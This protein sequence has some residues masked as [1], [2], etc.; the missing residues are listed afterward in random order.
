MIST[1]AVEHELRGCSY[2]GQSKPITSESRAWYDYS[3][4]VLVIGDLSS[5]PCRQEGLQTALGKLVGVLNDNADEP[6]A[7]PIGSASLCR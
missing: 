2:Y 7:T 3:D 5:V 4:S 6:L 1:G